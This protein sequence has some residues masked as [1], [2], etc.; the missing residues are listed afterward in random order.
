V[1][2]KSRGRT[3]ITAVY[4]PLGEDRRSVEG[5]GKVNG[6]ITQRWRCERGHMIDASKKPPR[7]TH[8]G[9]TAACGA[10]LTL[11]TEGIFYIRVE[12]DRSARGERRRRRETFRGTKTEAERRLRDILREAETG[13]FAEGSRITMKQVAERWLKSTQHRV[14]A[15]SYQRYESMVR[16]HIIPALGSLR[17]ENIRPAHVET[18]LASWTTNKR[19]DKKKKATLSQRSIAYLL[20]T[21]KTICRWAVRM[22]VF[23]RNPVDAIDPPRVDRKEMRALDTAGVAAL[24]D[25]AAGTDLQTPIA[26]AIGTGLRRGELLALRWGDIDLKAAK[27]AVRRSLETVDGITRTKSPKTRRSARTVSLAPFVVDVLTRA[28]AAQAQRRLE[29]G[30]GRDED[31][32]VFTRADASAWEPGAFS[33]HFARLVKGAKL[34]HVRFHDLRHTFGT[35][36]I[37]SGVDLETVSRALGH[38]STAITS[39]IYL[40][41]VESLQQDAAARIDGL[42]G[43]AVGNAMDGTGR[44]VNQAVPGGS[45]PQR[46]HTKKPSP[47]KPRNDGLFLVAPTR[48]ELVSPP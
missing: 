38:E 24:L 10:R 2:A 23:T 17:A 1:P 45:G 40:H 27:L 43:R 36:A 41:A 31:G 7:C 46:A 37:T 29:L 15:K 35:L 12:L 26:V 42:L 3:V 16:L 44:V 14:G 32:W 39:R 5:L 47:G 20:S 6:S 30:A 8:G 34:T 9:R 18:A 21:L 4:L 22:G 13:G 25:A 28:K 48:I 33:L 19:K 11:A